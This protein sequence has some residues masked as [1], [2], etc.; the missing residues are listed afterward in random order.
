MESKVSDVGKLCKSETLIRVSYWFG[1]RKDIVKAL[2]HLEF[3][4]QNVP[5]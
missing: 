5:N 1:V 3:A 2:Q 4:I